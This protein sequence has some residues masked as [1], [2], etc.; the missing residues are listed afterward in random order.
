MEQARGSVIARAACLDAS[1]AKRFSAV[2]SLWREP[3][4]FADTP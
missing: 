3:F 4:R 2:A 1:V